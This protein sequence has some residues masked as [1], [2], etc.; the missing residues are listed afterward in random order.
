MAVIPPGVPAR[1][2]AGK[3]TL[4][5]HALFEIGVIQA[6]GSVGMGA[7]R[8][9]ALELTR[10]RGSGVQA[11]PRRLARVIPAAG[12]PLL[13]FANPFDRLGARGETRSAPCTDFGR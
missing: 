4:S 8:A 7:T 5:E 1:V 9:D 10:A 6:V 2:D 11:Q 13:R 3:P 12:F